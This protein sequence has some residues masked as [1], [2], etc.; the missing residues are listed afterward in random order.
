MSVDLSLNKLRN[1]NDG[2][3]HKILGLKV[4]RLNGNLLKS[5]PNDLTQLKMLTSL[6]LSNNLFTE[7]PKCL[8]TIESLTFLDLSFNTINEI[9][10]DIGNLINLQNLVLASNRISGGLPKSFEKLLKL[11]ELD[12]RHNLLQSIDGLPPVKDLELLLE[13]NKISHIQFRFQDMTHFALNKNHLLSF[14]VELP[15]FD[16]VELNL[17]YNKLPQLADDIFNRFPL[18]ELL[19]LDSN[20][21]VAIPKSIVNLTKLLH[22][23]ACNNAI[24]AIPVG[25]NKLTLLR[26]LNLRN[27]NLK[28]LPTEIWS[29]NNLVTLNLSSNLLKNLPEVTKN[30]LL[31]FLPTRTRFFGGG[32]AT[33]T[34]DDSLKNESSNIPLAKSLENLYLADNCLTDAVFSRL[35]YFLK[36]KILNLSYNEIYD[37]PKN[38]FY[39]FRNLNCLYLSGN[40][41]TSLLAEEISRVP[42]L[43]ELYLN[44]NK[45][46][47]LP[48][49]IAKLPKLKVLDVSSNNL[50]Y[51]VCNWPYDWNW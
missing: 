13:G 48:A 46:Q 5:L 43:K 20:E 32:N 16:L 50:K 25:L 28:D 9:S 17:S 2:D 37:I 7:F 51:N 10:E 33:T 42:Q 12:V 29:L 23:S 4:L 26:T 35:V 14:E 18:L 30:S 45:L 11:K 34:T 49:D 15:L 19:N 6:Y 3:L 39:N 44:F 24:T 31:S 38:A 1:L 22:F 21:L 47:T 8:Y 40:N 41:I 36:L 27:N